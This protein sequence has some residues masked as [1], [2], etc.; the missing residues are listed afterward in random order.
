MNEIKS[1]QF[2][3]SHSLQTMTTYTRG[4]IKLEPDIINFNYAYP[5]LN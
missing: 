2:I 1:E 3:R 4:K 5:A